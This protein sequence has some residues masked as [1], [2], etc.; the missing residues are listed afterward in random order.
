MKELLIMQGVINTSTVL[1]T[2]LMSEIWGLNPEDKSAPAN[3]SN[4]T[5][6]RHIL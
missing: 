4:F 1:H 3:P 2:Q 6:S 5:E